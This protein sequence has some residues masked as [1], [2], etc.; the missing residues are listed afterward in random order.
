MMNDPPSWKKWIMCRLPILLA[1]C[2]GKDGIGK[3]ILA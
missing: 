1:G 3:L 2:A